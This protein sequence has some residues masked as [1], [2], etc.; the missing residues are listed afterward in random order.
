LAVILGII[1]GI[2]AIV[3]VAII[4]FLIVRRRRKNQNQI[5]Q[6]SVPLSPVASVRETTSTVEYSHLED[7]IGQVLEVTLDEVIGEGNF[8]RKMEDHRSCS[9]SNKGIFI[10]QGT[11]Q[12]N[13]RLKRL[14]SSQRY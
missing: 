11:F 4:L 3:S 14:T 13:F 5:V 9:E 6:T 8:Q 2:V 10:E 7:K 1:G 12:G